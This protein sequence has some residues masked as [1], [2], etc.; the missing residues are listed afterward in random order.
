MKAQVNFESLGG[1]TEITYT[2]VTVSDLSSANNITGLTEGDLV[3]IVGGGG[4]ATNTVSNI[5][6]AD[7]LIDRTGHQIVALSCIVLKA[8][9]STVYFDIS[10]STAYRYIVVLKQ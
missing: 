9:A 7:I 2:S 6:G 10:Y 8:T 4:S 1:G 3:L 5:S